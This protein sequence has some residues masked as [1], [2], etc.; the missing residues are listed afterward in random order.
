M[1]MRVTIGHAAGPTRPFRVAQLVAGVQRGL[2][3]GQSRPRAETSRSETI[4]RDRAQRVE[5]GALMG[6]A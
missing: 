4:G 2:G 6:A 3:L 5:P 1:M